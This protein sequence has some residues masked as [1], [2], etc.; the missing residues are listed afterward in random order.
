MGWSCRQMLDDK[1]AESRCPQGGGEMEVRKTEIKMG[2]C[3]KSDI[4]RVRE[5]WK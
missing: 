4:D 1:L 3:T 5:E 2:D